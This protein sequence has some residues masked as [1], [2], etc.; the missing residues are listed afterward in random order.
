MTNKLFLFIFFFLEEKVNF[1]AYFEDFVI[2]LTKFI[3]KT[4]RLIENGKKIRNLEGKDYPKEILEEDIEQIKAGN[5]ISKIDKYFNCFYEKQTTILD[6]LNKN[7]LIVLDEQRKIKQRAKNI[8]NDNENLIKALVEKEK[9]VP[10][11]LEDLN[12]YEEIQEKLKEKQVIYLEKED[13][14]NT[15][16]I[17]KYKFN[18]REIN[19]YRSEI[20]QFI[21]DFLYTQVHRPL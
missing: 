15:S 14:E 19:Y 21:K 2:R 18:Y 8:I 5:Y 6:Y 4:S 16:N 17:E 11:A 12:T 1:L 10:Q 13:N 20:E 3:L 7:Y 9:I